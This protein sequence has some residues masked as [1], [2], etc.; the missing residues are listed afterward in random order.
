M[1]VCVPPPPRRITR[2]SPKMRVKKLAGILGRTPTRQVR[3]RPP[4]T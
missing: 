1:C 3:P 4:R 2:L